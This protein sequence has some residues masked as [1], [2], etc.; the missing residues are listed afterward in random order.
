MRIQAR[1][2]RSQRSFVG[3]LT[4]RDYLRLASPR[5]P[6]RPSVGPGV[7]IERHTASSQRVHH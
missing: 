3:S 4:A 5:R 6:Q 2:A 7:V 1:S